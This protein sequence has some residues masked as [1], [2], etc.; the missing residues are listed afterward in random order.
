MNSICKFFKTCFIGKGS[1]LALGSNLP[2]TRSYIFAKQLTFSPTGT[3]IMTPGDSTYHV[4]TVDI[5]GSAAEV[6]AIPP[7]PEAIP[8]PTALAL[9]LVGGLAFLR[10]RAG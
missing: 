3:T 5:P 8:E 2:I 1:R 7:E 4:L 10:R 6:Q 9:L